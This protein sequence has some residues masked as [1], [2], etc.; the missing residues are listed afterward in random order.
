VATIVPSGDV[1][2]G[3]TVA[4][5]HSSSIET[6]KKTMK[7]R[8]GTARLIAGIVTTGAL[9]VGGIGLAAPAN[10][11][12]PVSP[13]VS[14]SDVSRTLLLPR[15]QTPATDPAQ[16]AR[17]DQLIGAFDQS[18]NT[19]SP[20]KVPAATLASA[21]G[22]AFIAEIAAQGASITTAS[23]ETH[24]LAASAASTAKS[25]SLWIDGWGVHIKASAAV[26]SALGAAA[27]GG[28]GT[29]G[30]VAAVLLANIE[31]F[32]VSTAGGITS[33]AIAAGL[34]AAAGILALCNLNG[35]GAQLNY[36]WVA[37]TCW[38]L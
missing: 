7:L 12:T 29:A 24:S 36:N 2:V 27:A 14:S 3:N 28:G 30:A 38:P 5:V 10:A 13:R 20:S 37:W 23:A 17:L 9:I 33:G 35:N 18:T 34:F 4:A 1:W 26:I 6:E 15:A 8:S 32:P 31:G 16:V 22:K 21:D 25:G 11:M 19:F